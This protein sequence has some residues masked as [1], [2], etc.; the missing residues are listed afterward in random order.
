[1]NGIT[2]YRLKSDYPG[3]YTKNCALNG[4]EV[5]NNFYVLEGRD[6]KSIAVNG[7]DIVVTLLNGDTVV[8]TDA[9]DFVKP[10]EIKTSIVKV[11]FDKLNGILTMTLADG[12][13]QKIE[14]FATNEN[15]DFSVAT[16]NTLCG[17]GLRNA[18]LG[19]APSARTGQYKTVKSFVDVASGASLPKCGNVFGDR[20]VTRED[21][22]DYG[23]LY[24][25]NSVRDIA[26][27]LKDT[28]WRI[29]TKADWDD[30]LNAIE[31]CDCDKTHDKADRNKVLG[32]WAGKLLKSKT[33]WV[34]CGCDDCSCGCDCNDCKHN[35]GCD[36]DCN[37]GQDTCFDYTDDPC[38]GTKE[39][40]QNCK[41][42]DNCCGDHKGL[43][44]YGFRVTPAGYADDGCNYSYFKERSAF[45]TATTDSENTK[46]YI[47]RFQFNKD[48]VYQDVIASNYHLS[49]RLVKDYD[50]K[51]YFDT[52]E[53]MDM[54][55]PTLLL[56]SVSKGKAIWTS[57]NFA[58]GNASLN[59]MLPNNGQGLT[60]TRHY[61][62]NEWDGFK[63]VR[64]EMKQ[65]ES[66]VIAKAPKGKEMVE[67]RVVGNDLVS[68]NEMIYK[69]VI[70][71]VDTE[72][73]KATQEISDRLDL[74]EKSVKT[75]T[76]ERIAADEKMQT[77]VDSLVEKTD[78]TNKNLAA[79]NDNLVTAINKINTDITQVNQ[80]L[81]D[82]INTINGGIATE[83]QERKDAD[84]ELNERATENKN[85]IDALVDKTD[86]T[87]E[88][89]SKTNQVLSD[90]GEE[91][92]TAFDTI[93][94]VIKTS[95]DNI[96]QSMMN[97]TDARIKADEGIKGNI[98]TEE[99][100]QFDSNEGVLTLKSE[101]GTNDIKVQFTFNFGTF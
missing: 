66:V 22:S 1:M 73:K 51:N 31:P 33:M 13:V 9:L 68:V 83:I 32:K 81:V 65:G 6:V 67:Y 48:G 45:W 55:Y 52:E 100:T 11:E 70:A 61:F 78:N 37:C 97:E 60:Y 75:E 41:C 56:P 50:G 38:V 2:Y 82:A 36:D 89:L 24:D 16:D 98:L 94:N 57:A 18:P 30:L 42:E 95:I 87:N 4:S 29:P 92:K 25:Y 77:S 72:I 69:D 91:T 71:D 40:T 62:I 84:A 17:D 46:A 58:C 19:V 43:D 44:A 88:E 14:G 74:V 28:G 86:K 85:N 8:A 47:K 3:D 101:S 99:G 76:E 5:D 53:I 96:N 39:C 93:N 59:P 80:N 54:E 26:C 21:I 90:F 15:T 12:T 49:L 7:K 79:V 63:W 20:Y 64:N 35:C 34:N 23:Y 10:D 27:E